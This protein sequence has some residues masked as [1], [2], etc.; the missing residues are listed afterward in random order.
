MKYCYRTIIIEYYVGYA[1][2]KKLLMIIM[3]IAAIAS[4]FAGCG[5]YNIKPNVPET[6]ISSEDAVF[7]G[8]SSAQQSCSRTRLIRSPARQASVSAVLY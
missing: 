3:I 5:R 1:N 8:F 7:N 2:E 4:V 6:K